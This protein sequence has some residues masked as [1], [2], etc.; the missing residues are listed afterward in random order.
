VILGKY[1]EIPKFAGELELN[2][3]GEK[4]LMHPNT[5]YGDIQKQ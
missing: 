1:D 2:E 5:P 4:V 3:K